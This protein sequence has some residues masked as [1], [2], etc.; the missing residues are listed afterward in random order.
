MGNAEREGQAAPLT[1]C[2]RCLEA[3][4]GFPLLI[5]PGVSMAPGH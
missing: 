3:V 2:L 4:R 5:V 1:H